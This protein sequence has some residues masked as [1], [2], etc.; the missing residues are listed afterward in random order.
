MTKKQHD[1]PALRSPRCT[2]LMTADKHSGKQLK[3][4]SQQHHHHPL[5]GTGSGAGGG[6]GT[7]GGG[8]HLE[9]SHAV[10]QCCISSEAQAAELLHL[11]CA[12]SQL[13]C[14]P[15]H[16]TTGLSSSALGRLQLT[17]HLWQAVAGALWL[18]P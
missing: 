13:P 11:C 9:L 12:G 8:R 10:C 1:T 15:G 14:K 16:L 5:Q 4:T 18:R 7:G 6:G 2:Q 17:P 3:A